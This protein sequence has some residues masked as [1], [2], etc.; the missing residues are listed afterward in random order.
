MSRRATAL[1]FALL[2]V[3]VRRVI[4]DRLARHGAMSASDLARGLSVTRTNVVQHLKALE[5]AGLVA[6]TTSDRRRLYR[7]ERSGLV[8]LREWLAQFD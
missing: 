7:I 6:A 5:R 1:I 4:F 3:P 2:A 8:P